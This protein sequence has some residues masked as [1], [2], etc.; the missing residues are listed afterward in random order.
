MKA[1]TGEYLS[2]MIQVLSTAWL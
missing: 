1:L 2:F